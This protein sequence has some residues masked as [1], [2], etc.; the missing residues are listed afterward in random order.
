MAFKEV[1]S[2]ITCPFFEE[3]SVVF[4]D[5]EDARDLPAFELTEPDLDAEVPGTGGTSSAVSLNLFASSRTDVCRLWAV[6]RGPGFDFV[7]LRGDDP[8]I[9]EDA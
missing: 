1:G 6:L 4:L 3:V 9:G 5:L 2:L 7:A 8:W